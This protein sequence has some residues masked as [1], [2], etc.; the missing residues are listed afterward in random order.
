MPQND[1]STPVEA[2]IFDYG[3]VLTTPVKDSIAA[4]LTRDRID[5]A[6]FS[7]TIKAWL[8]RTT[9]DDTPMK[10]LEIGAL[11]RSDFNVLLANE[12]V[13][14]DG[15]VV[16]PDELVTSLFADLRPEP[17]MFDM[18]RDLK[19]AG[20]R[21]AL[22]S[23]NWGTD[24]PRET[25]DEL[26]DTIVI[27]GEVGMRKPNPDIFLHTLDLLGLE[28]GQAAFIDDAEPNTEGA[29][30]LGIS[31]VLHRDPIS[32]RERVSHIVSNLEP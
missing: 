14:E 21:V 17:L 22:L 1:Q 26:F 11:T 29:A 13:K 18:A 8:G 31:A 16:S 9:P 24:Y 7:R 25:I 4:W 6:S 2:V 12:L 10:R 28:P 30:R 19:D 3:G 20:V 27:S 5:P 23:N 32:T 15:G